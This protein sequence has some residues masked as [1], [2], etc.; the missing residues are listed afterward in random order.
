MWGK[1]PRWNDPSGSGSVGESQDDVL[2]GSPTARFDDSGGSGGGSDDDIVLLGSP[3]GSPTRPARNVATPPS[4][5]RIAPPRVGGLHRALRELSA[6]RRDGAGDGDQDAAPPA[7]AA[8]EGRQKR[9]ASLT[10][11]DSPGSRTDGSRSSIQQEASICSDE[12]YEMDDFEIEQDSSTSAEFDDSALRRVASVQ[13]ASPGSAASPTS[14]DWVEDVEEDVV[15]RCAMQHAECPRR[16]PTFDL[17]QPYLHSLVEDFV[18][19]HVVD[20]VG[21]TEED[22]IVEDIIDEDDVDDDVV[23]DETTEPEPVLAPTARVRAGPSTRKSTAFAAPQQAPEEVARWLEYENAQLDAADTE[24][25]AKPAPRFGRSGKQPRMRRAKPSHVLQHP[26]GGKVDGQRL[27]GEQTDASKPS[28]PSLVNELSAR[29][30]SL[31]VDA[32]RSLLQ[33]LQDLDGNPDQQS[34]QALERLQLAEPEPEPELAVDLGLA[35][36][37]EAEAHTAERESGIAPAGLLRR[38]TQRVRL[39][40][41]SNWGGERQMGLSAV[42]LFDSNDEKIEVEPSDIS[43]R[44]VRG[45]KGDPSRLLSRD[46][47]GSKSELDMWICTRPLPPLYPDVDILVSADISIARVRVYNY[48]AG[49]NSGK[50]VREMELF[51]NEHRQWQGVLN[52]GGS[53]GVHHTDISAMHRRRRGAGHRQRQRRRRVCG[54]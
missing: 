41:L 4:A 47:K 28:N 26:V 46:K 35:V 1:A 44:G 33:K 19:D 30:A 37:P 5:E 42:E 3:S 34:N 24:K 13:T 36:R 45:D 49:N 23:H 54:G 16:V 10:A 2:L 15:E 32:Q 21:G 9:L 43:V 12:A 29:L 17:I 38:H 48:G 25:Q 18:E 11:A 53:N 51:V 14:V 6:L 8:M 31:D 50:E 40:L 52:R 20:E 7:A 22:L 27:M 39:R